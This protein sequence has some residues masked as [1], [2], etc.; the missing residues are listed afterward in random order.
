MR[1]VRNY[2]YQ[3]GRGIAVV[4]AV[5]DLMALTAGK[6]RHEKTDHH[7]D[8]VSNSP[9]QYTSA[10]KLSNTQLIGNQNDST[11]GNT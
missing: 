5:R 4:T 3:D 2:A 11:E 10:E 1:E 8:R 7:G 6:D 9:I